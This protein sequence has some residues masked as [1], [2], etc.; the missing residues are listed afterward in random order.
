MSI[1]AAG[2]IRLSAEG[3]DLG[4]YIN[5]L[6]QSRVICS[7][8]YCRKNIFYA[9]ILR[10]DLAEAEKI[11]E[12]MDI[13]LYTEEYETLSLKLRRYRRRFGIIIGAALVFV[14]AVYFSNVVVTIDIQGN[15]KVSDKAILAA[16]EELDIKTGTPIK[17]INFHKCENELRIMMKDISWAAIRHTGNRLVVDVREIVPAPETEK[18]RIPCHIVA[19]RDAEITYTS[20]LDG[21]LM[22]KVGDFV[23]KGTL[24]VNGVI[25]DA[26]GHTTLHHAMGEIRGTYEEKVIF[27]GEYKVNRSVPT[28]RSRNEKCLCL[29]SARIPL[30]FGK[31]DYEASESEI[32]ESYL[33]LFGKTL[34]IGIR[35]EKVSETEVSEHILTKDELKNELAKKIFLYEKNFLSDTTVIIDRNITEEENDKGMTLTVTY[36]LEGNIGIQKDIFVDD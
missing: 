34:P 32:S 25:R 3:K 2:R 23:P 21:M 16:L 1:N 20:A 10:R 33:S 18:K 14:F 11:A 9:D 5:A 7:G 6:H 15:D 26:T 4:R 17:N 36:R 35:H 29:F 28:G 19:A 13:T 30:F 12:G 31:N 22:H 24:I 8:Q 27:T